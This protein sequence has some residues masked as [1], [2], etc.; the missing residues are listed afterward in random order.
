MRGR[1]QQHGRLDYSVCR[2]S[3]SFRFS[4]VLSFVIAGLDP[5]IHAAP[6][7]SMDHRVKPGGDED[8]AESE[9]KAQTET[10]APPLLFQMRTLFALHIRSVDRKDSRVDVERERE[11]SSQRPL[12]LRERAARQFNNKNG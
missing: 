6:P 10:K 3:I 4:S 11:R 9:A 7:L 2:R 12:P 1:A 5:A 8:R